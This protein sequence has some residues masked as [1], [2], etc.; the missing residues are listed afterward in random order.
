MKFELNRAGV[1]E[2]LQS[3]GA[4]DVCEDAARQALQTLDPG[5]VSDT[6]IGRNRVR[7]EVRPDTPKAY[8]QNKAHNTVLKAVRS[9]K[10]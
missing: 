1:R 2:L 3:D 5:Y 4:R 7:V 10:I 9:V 8:Y 6:R